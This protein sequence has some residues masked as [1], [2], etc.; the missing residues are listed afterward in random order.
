MSLISGFFVRRCWGMVEKAPTAHSQGHVCFP[1][2]EGRGMIPLG[3]SGLGN[4][5]HLSKCLFSPGW[6]WRLDCLNKGHEG[7]YT[8]AGH[9]RP[10]F[11]P[12]SFSDVNSKACYIYVSITLAYMKSWGFPVPNSGRDNQTNVFIAS[13]T[14][15]GFGVRAAE[16]CGWKG[17]PSPSEGA[18]SSQRGWSWPS[19]QTWA[20]P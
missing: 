16:E 7:G 8:G 17:P 3:S 2:S 12:S 6:V 19:S 20:E 4:K 15:K 5:A 13:R 11:P 10:V 18:H 1:G 9:S 14:M